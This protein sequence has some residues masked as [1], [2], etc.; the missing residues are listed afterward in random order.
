VN[1]GT[2][3]TDAGRRFAEAH[4]IHRI[5]GAQGRF[6]AVRLSDGGTDGTVYDTMQDAIAHQLHETQCYYCCVQPGIMSDRDATRLLEVA[7]KLY[8]AGGRFLTPDAVRP[9]MGVA[10]QEFRARFAKALI[11]IARNPRMADQL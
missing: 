11:G 8:D 6:I 1:A 9:Q 5:A 3:I 10:D 4:N 2:L 7:R